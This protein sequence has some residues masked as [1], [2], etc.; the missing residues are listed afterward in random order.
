VQFDPITYLR[1]AKGNHSTPAAVDLASSG[2]ASRSLEDLNPRPE[3]L[4]LTAP[5]FYGLPALHEAIAEH[6]GVQA[7]E[8]L[9]TAGSSMANFLATMSLTRPGDTVL[10]E[11]P[12]YEPLQRL[13]ALFGCSVAPI[14]RSESDGWALDPTTLGEQ[15]QRS[16]ATLAIIT[17]PH[18]PSGVFLD[19]GRVQALHAACADHACTLLVDEVYAEFHPHD[20]AAI[21]GL[22]QERL[23]RTSSLTKVLGFG[24]LR[25]GWALASAERI[26]HMH[27]LNDYAMV[28][29][30]SINEL[31]G[32]E[33]WRERE[34][35]V[36]EAR[37][38]GDFNGDIVRRFLSSRDDLDWVDP[39]HGIL[40][41]LQV[42]GTPDT[43]VLADHLLHEYGVVVVPG[44]HFGRPDSIRIGFGASADMVRKGLQSLGRALDEGKR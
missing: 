40:G 22:V 35:F 25:L 28:M 26:A 3:G 44:A 8:V 24:P 18:N 37:R 33:V 43:Q 23:V 5:N 14:P 34:R 6:H 29:H 41:F 2:M 31:L 42:Q 9:I 11:A 32:L 16:G 7:D 15:V 38:R 13:P 21:G 12:A 4:Q 19:A 10:V 39:K 20:A 36:D 17:N 30:G 27:A 1:W